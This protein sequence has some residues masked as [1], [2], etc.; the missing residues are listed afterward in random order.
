MIHVKIKKSRTSRNQEYNFFFIMVTMSKF[1]KSM[2]LKTQKGSKTLNIDGFLHLQ[3]SSKRSSVSLTYTVYWK[4]RNRTCA[5]EDNS[6]RLGNMEAED[7]KTKITKD[8]NEVLQ[9]DF[10]ERNEEEMAGEHEPLFHPSRSSEDEYMNMQARQQVISNSANN[11]NAH[12]K[13]SISLT[14]PVLT[15]P[16]Y[17][18][19][20]SYG[21]FLKR[22]SMSS[23]L[24][25]SCVKV[26]G[27]SPYSLVDLR[28]PDNSPYQSVNG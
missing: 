9:G 17:V 7:G 8:N 28:I 13:M 2:Y 10:E 6:I 12:R 15:S 16:E 24:S 4:C 3:N 14:D 27:P 23:A 5:G 26:F 18:K 22:T 19:A 21:G 20:R 25:R 1:D 11:K